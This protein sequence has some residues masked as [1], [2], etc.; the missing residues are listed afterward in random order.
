[1]GGLHRAAPAAALT[2]SAEAE[3]AGADAATALAGWAAASTGQRMGSGWQRSAV[4]SA[5]AAPEMRVCAHPRRSTKTFPLQ[6]TDIQI[7]RGSG[8]NPPP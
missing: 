7:M 6:E 8:T 5:D 4:A 3:G 2:H 1:M